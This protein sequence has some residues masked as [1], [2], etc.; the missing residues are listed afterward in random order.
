MWPVDAATSPR[1]GRPTIGIIGGG[2]LGRMLALAAS[3]LGFE[4]VVLDPGAGS[5]AAQVGA[6]QIV[7]DFHDPLALRKLAEVSDFVTIEFE[8]LDAGALREIAKTSAASFN[9]TP[10][11]ISLIQDKLRQKQFLVEHGIA[12][13]PFAAVE[14]VA[15]AAVALEAYG[16]MV[17]KTRTGG[18]D[19]RGNRVVTSR[20]EL[21]E[22]FASFNGTSLYAEQLVPF[23]KELA[24]MV[25]RSTAGEV[26]A[27]PVVETVHERNICV[28]VLAPAPVDAEVAARAERMATDV[29]A[30]FDGAGMFGVEMFLA[31]SGEVLV[32]EIAPRVHNS[33][34]YTQDV[35]RTSQFEQHVRAI[36]GLPLGPTD[37]TAPAAA[38]VNIL[39]ERDGA[40]DVVGVADALAVPHTN[41]HLYGKSPTKVDR[42]MGHINA[43]GR[44]VAEA[45]S[46]ARTARQR[47]TV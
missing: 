42:K 22:A 13:G 45:R 37:L 41:L 11:T 40:T 29:A 32:N 1:C 33:G 26:V 9:P 14:N 24:V 39:G 18:F 38:M 23:E 12:V 28:E 20:V 6:Q 44:D 16:S 21:A 35:S 31:S 46:R 34:H 36:T 3:P 5:P 47:L 43:T 7:G 4:V 17:L 8:H 30:L 25:A 10:A 19:G 15:A 2:Q 27:Y